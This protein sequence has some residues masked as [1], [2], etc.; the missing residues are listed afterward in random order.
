[1]H[2]KY[3]SGVNRILRVLQS[4]EEVTEIEQFV[5][6][7]VATSMLDNRPSVL[8]LSI[9]K[10]RLACMHLLSINE[11]DPMLHLDI[12]WHPKVARNLEIVGVMNSVKFSLQVEHVQ[13]LDISQP[14]G[15]TYGTSWKDVL[16]SV[17]S[18]HT[19]TIKGGSA[20]SV[21]RALKSTVVQ[22][23][24]EEERIVLLPVLQ[25]LELS[26]VDISNTDEDEDDDD[27]EEASNKGEERKLS[28]VLQLL[29]T[30]RR[31]G[32]Q[33]IRQLKMERCKEISATEV[34][35]LKTLAD[36]T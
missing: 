10:H 19:L 18:L 24:K 33:P 28:V 35:V 11:L 14:P 32:G 26:H 30:Q 23:D 9:D 12:H 7:E 4:P 16:R 8:K 36:V 25:R 6:H 31:N 34:V 27:E 1:M 29:F 15:Y 13:T 2:L 17:P 5:C 22:N 3:P 20:F 21:I